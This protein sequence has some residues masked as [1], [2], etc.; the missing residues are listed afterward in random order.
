[1]TPTTADTELARIISAHG[2]RIRLQG[3]RLEALR[4]TCG[5]GHWVDI[6]D[7]GPAE[8]LAWLGY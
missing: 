5:Y 2:I 7:M 4:V 3:G 8:L 6:S 1:M